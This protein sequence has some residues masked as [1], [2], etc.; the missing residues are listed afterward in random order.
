MK[1]YRYIRGY[2]LSHSSFDI[3][4]HLF[5]AEA[6]LFYRAQKIHTLAITSQHN[7]SHIF[8]Y[9]SPKIIVVY[10]EMVEIYML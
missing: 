10:I 4:K 8:S 2:A 1:C 9:I 7:D 6:G 3:Q 5:E